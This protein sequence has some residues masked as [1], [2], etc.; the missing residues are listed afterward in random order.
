[1]KA[2]NHIHLV[3]LL[4]VWYTIRSLR[5]IIKTGYLKYLNACLEAMANNPNIKLTF[6]L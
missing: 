3:K 5:V 6:K 4:C 1:M 2:N